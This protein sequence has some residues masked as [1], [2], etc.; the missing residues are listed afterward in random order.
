MRERRSRRRRDF[1]V[2]FWVAGVRC[3]ASVAVVGVGGGIVSGRALLE[4]QAFEVAGH[5]IV[6]GFEGIVE[7]VGGVLERSQLVT[8]LEDLAAGHDVDSK[9]G[10]DAEPMKTSISVQNPR[11]FSRFAYHAGP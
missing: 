9:G 11:L 7:M 4:R 10:D 8:F 6:C 3:G 1:D 5:L 2:V